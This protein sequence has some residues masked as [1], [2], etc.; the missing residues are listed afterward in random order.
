MTIADTFEM[1][2][3][4]AVRGAEISLSTLRM[5]KFMEL[6][7]EELRTKLSEHTD[8]RLF[9]VFEALYR[10]ISISEIH[11]ATF[12]DEWFLG[13]LAN[14]VAFEKSI[15][16]KPLDEETYLCGKRLG[17]TD[18]TLAT[19]SGHPINFHAT[20]TYKMVDT[21][22]GEFSAETPY[23]YA[24]YDKGENEAEAFTKEM[25]KP[26][27]LVLGSGPIRIGQ[28]IEFDYASVHCVWA[29]QRLGYE[30]IIIN[31]NPEPFLPISTPQIAYI[32]NH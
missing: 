24:T 31:N 13:K 25:C 29:L 22:A 27:L 1:A 2:I 20:P 23:F 15:A 7:D 19:L 16:G 14:L 8:E 12:I 9:V 28:G 3:M 10:N 5:P 11:N 17:Y 21:C 30:V 18:Q 6:R 26:R 4:K 32:L